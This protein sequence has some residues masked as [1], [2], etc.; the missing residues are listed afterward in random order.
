MAEVLLLFFPGC[1]NAAA[2]RQ[3]LAEAFQRAGLKPDWREVNLEEENVSPEWKG[4]GSP[5]VLVGGRDVCGK[6]PI[7]GGISCRLYGESECAPS[8]EIILSALRNAAQVSHE[9]SGKLRLLAAFPGLLA[10]LLPLGACP[11][12]YPAYAAVLSSLGLGFL[13]KA[14]YVLPV[15]GSFLAFGIGALA[16]KARTRRGYRP[17][18]LGLV[19]GILILLGKFQLHMDLLGYVGIALLL[20]ASLWNAWPLRSGGASGS[21]PACA[22]VPAKGDEKNGTPLDPVPRSG[23]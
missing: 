5:T 4:Y 23:A 10:S 22:T 14:S 20:G 2:T 9:G 3:N 1:P 21:C 18:L 17:F 8:V 11:A 15:T 6:E 7:S 13:G 12:C 16:W 19:G